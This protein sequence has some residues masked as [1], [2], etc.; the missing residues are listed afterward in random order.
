MNEISVNPN[1]ITAELKEIYNSA[2]FIRLAEF[3]LAASEHFLKIAGENFPLDRMKSRLTNE[4][5]CYLD[6]GCV[7]V[8]SNK[9]KSVINEGLE[10]L[11]KPSQ[12]AVELK[13]TARKLYDIADCALRLA[14]EETLAQRAEQKQIADEIPSDEPK[15]SQAISL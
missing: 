5:K 10:S 2:D 1:R 11:R 12:T 15:V 8:K 3:S 13:I 9:L 6:K 4:Y 14:T 7:A